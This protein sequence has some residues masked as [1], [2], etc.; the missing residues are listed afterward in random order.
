MD[1]SNLHAP[2]VLMLTSRIVGCCGWS[3]CGGADP[4]S[5]MKTLGNWSRRPRPTP[6]VTHQCQET[7]AYSLCHTPVSGD[8]GLLLVSHTSVRRPRPTP[9]VTHQCQETSAYSLCHTPVSGDL[10]LLLVSN[11]SARRPRP[12]PCCHTPVSGDLGLLLVS[13]TIVRRPR[14]SP[15][16]HTPVLR[17]F[18]KRLIQCCLVFSYLWNYI[19]RRVLSAIF[20]R[21]YGQYTYNVAQ[22]LTNQ[23]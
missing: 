14:P 17:S 3:R 18:V 4:P 23:A 12:T 20:K 7:S 16:C 13:H 6:C 9:C 5:L 22:C 15:C 8:L 2:G 11:T 19:C 10:G 1:L 21:W